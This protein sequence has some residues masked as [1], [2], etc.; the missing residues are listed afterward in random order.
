[1]RLLKV[2]SHR[3]VVVIALDKLRILLLR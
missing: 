3:L 2:F 1:M